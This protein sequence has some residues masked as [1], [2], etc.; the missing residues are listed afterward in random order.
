M[1]YC[2][3]KLTKFQFTINVAGLEVHNYSPAFINFVRH[4]PSPGKFYR[5]ILSNKG[6]ELFPSNKYVENFPNFK[7]IHIHLKDNYIKLI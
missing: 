6:L 7:D 2:D 1:Q 3:K 5:Q 4:V